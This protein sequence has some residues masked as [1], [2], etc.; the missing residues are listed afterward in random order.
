MAIIHLA[1]IRP[2][3]PELL[4]A[5]LPSQPWYAGPEGIEVEYVGAYR[6]DDPAGE[7]GIESHLVRVDGVVY[8]V[9]LTYRGAPLAGADAAFVTTMEHSVLGRRWIYDACGDPVYVTVLAE[10]ILVRQQQ[11]EMIVQGDEGTERREPTAVVAGSG[12]TGE[13]PTF[14]GDAL[15]C[16][17]AGDVTVCAAPGLELR[18]RRVV[19]DSADPGGAPCLTG[20]W[21]GQDDPALLATA[22]FG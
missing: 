1:Q 4:S 22:S 15:T 5:W 12:G 14:S 19:D 10:V 8:H 9:P 18:V 6:F 20:T 11:A 17:T 21:A 7:V 16:T 3:K 13:V 2:T